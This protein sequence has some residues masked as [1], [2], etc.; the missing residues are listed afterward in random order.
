MENYK[1]LMKLGFL[2]Y[3]VQKIMNTGLGF[4]KLQ[5]VW[6]TH[7]SLFNPGFVQI[8]SLAQSGILRGVSLTTDDIQ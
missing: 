7:N 4:F 3:S 1:L 8:I 5:K 6:K 2:G